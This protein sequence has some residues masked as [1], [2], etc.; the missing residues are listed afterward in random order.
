MPPRR[1]QAQRHAAPDRARKSNFILAAVAVLVI[2]L[3][4]AERQEL[5]HLFLG[6]VAVFFGSKTSTS[7]TTPT[8]PTSHTAT[9]PGAVDAHAAAAR[10]K[11]QNTEGTVRREIRD[12]DSQSTGFSWDGFI[13]K[14]EAATKGE[15]EWMTEEEI[16]E[17]YLPEELSC[18]ENIT[19]CMS[20]P[21]VYSREWYHAAGHIG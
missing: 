7:A 20:P 17:Y 10:A 21:R 1:S 12:R 13:H 8:N 15:W 14:M 2:V 6:H 4:V 19:D 5:D 3:I 18:F 16:E 11:S 9:T